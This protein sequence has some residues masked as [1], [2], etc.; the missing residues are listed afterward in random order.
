MDETEFTLENHFEP[1]FLWPQQNAFKSDC[2]KVLKLNQERTS[3][4]VETI[5]C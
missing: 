3:S 2:L 4:S 1:E 5:S